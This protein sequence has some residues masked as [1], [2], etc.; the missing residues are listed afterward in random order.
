VNHKREELIQLRHEIGLE[1]PE[2]LMRIY[3]SIRMIDIKTFSSKRE[4]EKLFSAAESAMERENYTELRA[5]LGNIYS[6][7]PNSEQEQVN[8]K[9]TG[10][11]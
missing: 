6:L 3:Y 11:N 4:A 9:G 2:Y 10:L 7:L 5:I 8:I 1:T